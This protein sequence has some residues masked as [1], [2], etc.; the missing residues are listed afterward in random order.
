MTTA[1]L[2]RQLA[3]S[4]ERIADLEQQNLA[5][6]QQVREMES[7]KVACEPRQWLTVKEAAELLGRSPSFLHKDR[8]LSAPRLPYRQERESGKVFYSRVDLDNYSAGNMRGRKK[9]A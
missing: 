5:L 6:L 8:M 4:A 1:D 9:S 7:A 3:D 2:Y